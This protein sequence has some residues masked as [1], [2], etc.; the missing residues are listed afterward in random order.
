MSKS[1]NK[2]SKLADSI[3]FVGKHLNKVATSSERITEKEIREAGGDIEYT[4]IPEAKSV[5]IKIP[6]FPPYIYTE[7]MKE[8]EKFYR[9]HL[10]GRTLKAGETTEIAILGHKIPIQTISTIPPNTRVKVTNKTKIILATPTLEKTQKTEMKITPAPIP[11][12]IG[13]NYRITIPKE[14]VELLQLKEGEII[15]IVISKQPP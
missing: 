1:K 13:K 15:W 10:K 14:W 12:K 7:M 6:H 5:T 3:D 4:E 8:E 2:K 11:I 9:T